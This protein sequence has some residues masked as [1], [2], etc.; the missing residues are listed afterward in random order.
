MSKTILD[1]PLQDTHALNNANPEVLRIHSIESM[2]TQDGPG[3][4]LVIFV[5][6]C[7]FRCL[8]C[9]NPD[10]LDVKEGKFEPFQDIVNRMERMRNYFGDKGGITISGR[11]HMLQRNKTKHLFE[12]LHEKGFNTCV[13]TNGR[14]LNEEVKQ[15][16]D[17]TDLVLLDIKHMDPEMHK[18]LTGLSNKNTLEFAAYREQSAKRMWLRHVLVPGWTDSEEHLHQL[19]Q[20]FKDYKNVECI[21]ILPY[22]KLGVHKYKEMGLDYKLEGVEPPTEESKARAVAILS[23]YFSKVKLK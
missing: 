4:R 1:I 20:H 22:H 18:R 3:I 21:E 6:G 5:Q 14:L 12:I 23:Q 11:D 13:D 8:Y 2:G 7:E 16:L 17:E 19:G 10:T 9:H 15:M